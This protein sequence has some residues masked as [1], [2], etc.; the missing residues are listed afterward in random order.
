MH[1]RD[2]VIM[3]ELDTVDQ[4]YFFKEGKVDVG[5]DINRITKFKVRLQAPCFIGAFECTF[6][7][8]SWYIYKVKNEC[9]GFFMRKMAWSSLEE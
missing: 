1:P 4:V 7:F 3:N 5:Y 8:R 9:E 2:T 6:K